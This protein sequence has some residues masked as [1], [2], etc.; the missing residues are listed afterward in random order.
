MLQQRRQAPVD[1]H[2]S[3]GAEREQQPCSQQQV[4]GWPAQCDGE[5]SA[6]TAMVEY[7]HR[8]YP[9]E[10]RDRSGYTSK[11]IKMKSR[12]RLQST[13]LSRATVTQSISDRTLHP[14][15]DRDP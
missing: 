9:S 6:A 15:V 1:A 2:A 8:L 12:V 11:R 7:F 10:P 3:A 4:D 13:F 14:P 5:G